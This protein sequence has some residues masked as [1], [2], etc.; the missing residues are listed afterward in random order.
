[1]HL[2]S[3]FLLGHFKMHM[4]EMSPTWFLILDLKVRRKRGGGEKQKNTLPDWLPDHDVPSHM[5]YNL[6]RPQ[7]IYKD[8]LRLKTEWDAMVP[9]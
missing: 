8:D 5:Q 4:C 6:A 7:I 1:M 9:F 3:L 2:L